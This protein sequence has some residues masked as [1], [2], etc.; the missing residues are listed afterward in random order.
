MRPQAFTG[1]NPGTDN[2]ID[3]GKKIWCRKYGCWKHVKVCQQCGIQYRCIE[4][5]RYLIPP[6]FEL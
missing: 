2:T 1:K 4:F 5:K 6:L 3:P